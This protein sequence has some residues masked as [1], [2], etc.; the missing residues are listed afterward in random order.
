[1]KISSKWLKQYIDY[2]INPSNIDGIV[3]K[4]A[5]LGF[6]TECV[7]HIQRNYDKYVAGKV[8]ECAKHPNADK[9]TL[10]KVDTGSEILPIV[11]GAPNV[12]A[13]QKLTS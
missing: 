7:E 6:E 11:C 9:L 10:C 3:K 5:I 2:D 8:T 12:R 1:M 4:L 13:G